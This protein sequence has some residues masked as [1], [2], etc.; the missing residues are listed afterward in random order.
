MES[1]RILFEPKRSDPISVSNKKITSS[2][3]DITLGKTSFLPFRYNLKSYDAY[4]KTISLTSTSTENTP[5][6]IE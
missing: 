3:D 2:I 4:R 6:N 1:V 5:I